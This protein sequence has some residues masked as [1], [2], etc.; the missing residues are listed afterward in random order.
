MRLW[1]NSSSFR[2]RWTGRPRIDWATRFSLRALVRSAV[3]LA[4]AAVSDRRRG[5]ACLLIALLLP[6]GLLVGR[7][8]VEGA[9]RRD[10][11]ELVTHHVLG[12]HHRHMLLAVVD[13]EGQAD[14]L[15]HDGGA[16]RP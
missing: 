8:A 4:I 3:T 10:L 5:L 11:A 6:L 2:A 1:L 9:G 15:R 16:A 12:H 7:V 13:A 14:E